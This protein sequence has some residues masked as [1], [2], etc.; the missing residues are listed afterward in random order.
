M[1]LTINGSDP[2]GDL[3]DLLDE[4]ISGDGIQDIVALTQAEYDALT[5]VATTL[6]VVTD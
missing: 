2:T 4:K 5:P 3:G 1:A 6:Y